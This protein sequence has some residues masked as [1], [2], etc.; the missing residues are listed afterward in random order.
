MMQRVLIAIGAGLAAAILFV[1]PAKG[2]AMAMFVAVL[3]ALPI[4]IAG[5]GFGQATALI[6]GGIGAILISIFL[7]PLF[8]GAFLVSVALPSWWLA[9]QASLCRTDEDGT[10]VWYPISLLLGWIVALAIAMTLAIMGL[11]IMQA[12]GYTEFIETSVR[13]LGPAL[14]GVLGANI[15]PASFS[16]EDFARLIVGLMPSVMAG[17]A[18]AS[19]ALNLWL[20]GRVVLISQLL[21]RTWEDLPEHLALP[22]QARHF[23][24]IGLIGCL[25]DGPIRMV[26]STIAAA[27]GVAYA[28]Q[29]LAAVHYISRGSAA[30][31]PILM[32]VYFTVMVM[33]PWPL[34]FAAITGLI[35]TVY[36]LRRPKTPPKNPPLTPIN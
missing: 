19:L 24:I 5:L 21:T 12:G 35:E 26:G 29:G 11:A 23:F 10:I 16:R 14:D 25:I 18:A 3:S 8:G 22:L 13:R 4:M 33:L 32:G 9:R 20:A 31:T 34:I 2:T 36:P 17:W 7:I 30:R 28:F 1:V 27:I 15:L 6:A